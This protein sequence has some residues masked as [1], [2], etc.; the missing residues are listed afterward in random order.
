[1][2]QG[3]G[4]LKNTAARPLMCLLGDCAV[5]AS[6]EKSICVLVSVCICCLNVSVSW[7]SLIFPVQVTDTPFSF[8]S[9][10]GSIIAPAS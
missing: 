5:D 9:E 4:A 10:H 7:P 6:K 3:V 8:F 1:M 2:L